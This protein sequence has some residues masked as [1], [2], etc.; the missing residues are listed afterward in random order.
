M[1]RRLTWT[2]ASAVAVLAA[3]LAVLASTTAPARGED[4]YVLHEFKT[5]RLTDVYY[6]EGANFGD[7]NKDGKLDVVCGP[8]WYEGPDLV[9][10][11]EIYPAK[12]YPNDRGY[13]ENNFFSFAHDFNGDGWDDLL[14]YG[15]PGTPAYLYEN[16]QGKEGNWTRHE[17]FPAIDNESPTF[18]DITGD[19]QPEIV[20]L[21]GGKLGYATY[22]ADAPQKAWSFHPATGQGNWGRFTHGL[23]VGDV[24]GDGKLDL[25]MKDGWWEQPASLE[26]DPEWKHHPFAFA[27][28][29]G[30]AQMFA[31]DVDGDG[32]NDVITS[33]EAHAYGLS[34][35]RNVPA[36][37]G[38][39]TFEEHKIMTDKP[40]GSPYGVCYTE[41]HALDLADMDGDGLLDIVT[42]KCYF[43]HNGGGPGGHDPAVMYY[44]KLVR[45]GGK[46]DFVPM[47]MDDDSGVGR[48]VIAGDLNG[49]GLM[50]AVSGNK[51]GAFAWIQSTR[52]VS[53]EEWEKAQPK[54]VQ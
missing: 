33:L 49:D 35:F 50:D 20:C 45:D 32:R 48:Q 4:D 53:K 47:L 34:W 8:Y 2:A 9:E 10:K 16:P 26:G 31:Y 46:A 17:V 38:G 21:F 18:L 14:T 7:F 42:G 43:S 36:D 12:P 24:N 44:F 40:E 30:G 27:P 37:D 51:K 11:H 19:G 15:L 3:Q 41:L 5:M 22:D 25:L 54:R 28:G 29:M 6:S 13:S 52:K 39:I 23:G 1:S